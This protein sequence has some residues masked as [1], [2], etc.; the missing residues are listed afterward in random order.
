MVYVLD[1]E[2]QAQAK[3]QIAARALR[4]EGVELAM[5]L[6]R[7]AH[8]APSEAVI[9]RLGEADSGSRS[10]GHSGARGAGGGAVGQAGARA[11]SG[12]GGSLAAGA[13]LRELR[14]RPGDDV[15]DLR[16]RAWSL[17]GELAV[18]DAEQRDGRLHAPEHPD[19]LARAWSALTC[20]ASGDV[21]LSAAPGHE[22]LDL[23]GQAHVGGGSHGSLRAEDSL[24]AA[25]ICG[26]DGLDGREQWAIADVAP[27]IERY[28]A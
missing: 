9:A 17:E 27:L 23:G 1:E 14:F 16:G 12:R 26:I 15:R 25:I 6:E 19:A 8:G 7:D 22:F 28:F 4:V 10:G 24:G 18:L 13:G 11:G 5:W 3:A 20:P 2:A 21:L